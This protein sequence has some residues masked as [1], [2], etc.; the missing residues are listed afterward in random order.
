MLEYTY[1]DGTEYCVPFQHSWISTYIVL[2]SLAA[3]FVRHLELCCFTA[4]LHV[5]ALDL[6]S[7]AMS[8]HAM[9]MTDV[10]LPIATQMTLSY[11]LHSRFNSLVQSIE[12]SSSA[13][14]MALSVLLFP[15][16]PEWVL[17][18]VLTLSIPR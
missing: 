14:E 3:L 1:W 15:S 6:S 16:D 13:P 4:F 12:F 11:V 17:S 8:L 10:F 18:V 7:L 9:A 2:C 5:L